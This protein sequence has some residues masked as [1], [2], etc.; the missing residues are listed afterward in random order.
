MCVY[1]SQ[2]IATTTTTRRLIEFDYFLCPACRTAIIISWRARY[3]S[4]QVKVCMYSEFFLFLK[5]SVRSATASLLTFTSN[6]WYLSR[7][8]W[9][10]C[11]HHPLS[12]FSAWRED[13]NPHSFVSNA[14][15]KLMISSLQ[16]YS[17]FGSKPTR[18]VYKWAWF[19]VWASL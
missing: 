11:T 1:V 5:H 10:I 8:G 4:S 3:F 15:V 14:L 19:Y 2:P 17:V 12:S 16:H 7:S 6:Y 13:K 9:M 18:S